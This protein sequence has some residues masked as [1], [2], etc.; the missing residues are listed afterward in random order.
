V[1]VFAESLTS[2]TILKLAFP[3]AVEVAL[4]SMVFADGEAFEGEVMIFMA[5]NFSGC[6]TDVQL[7]F[8]G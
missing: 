7:M 4:I 3:V 8:N 2:Q 1:V 6:L 5:I